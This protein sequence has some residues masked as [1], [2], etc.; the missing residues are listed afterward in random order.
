MGRVA[1]E[2]SDYTLVTSD[3]PRGESPDVIMDAIMSGVLEG[4]P[5]GR[6][7][8]RRI[9][10]GEA[11][12]RSRVGDVVVVAGKGHET[13]QILGDESVPFDDRVVAREMLEST[14]C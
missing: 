1:S 14:T 5:V 6:E 4:S 9:A 8:D 10:I 12:T 3:N 13:Y 7:V 11:L 2:L